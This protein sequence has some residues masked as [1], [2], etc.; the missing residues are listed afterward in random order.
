MKS[1]HDEI[2]AHVRCVC[3]QQEC[4]V[5]EA[6]IDIFGSPCTG[7]SHRGNMKGR[8]DPTSA[9]QLVHWHSARAKLLVAEN[10]T[11]GQVHQLESDALKK[12]CHVHFIPT[13]PRD[14]GFRSCSRHRGW[15]I[16]ATRFRYAS[17]FFCTHC[18]CIVDLCQCIVLR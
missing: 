16:A 3:H 18:I 7:S 1:H 15:H 9:P 6:D 13:H 5:D 14:S 11:T 8:D 12:N 17:C 2:H 10:V 4:N